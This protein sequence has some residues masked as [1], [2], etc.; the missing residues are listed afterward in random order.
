M[1]W[2]TLV[3]YPVLNGAWFSERQTTD[4]PS[5]LWPVTLSFRAQA[6]K[7]VHKALDLL[8]SEAEIGKDAFDMLRSVTDL[9]PQVRHYFY[10]T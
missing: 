7:I 2:A 3:R 10:C 6:Q 1:D 8:H 9:E 4:N 5:Q